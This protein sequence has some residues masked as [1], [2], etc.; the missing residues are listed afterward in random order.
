MPAVRR[1]RFATL[2]SV[3]AAGALVVSVAGCG[4]DDASHDSAKEHKPNAQPDGQH[5]DGTSGEGDSSDGKESPSLKLPSSVPT[6][7]EDLKDWDWDNWKHWA[8]QKVFKN[9]RLK[10]LWTPDRMK[11]AKPADVNVASAPS[12]DRPATDPKPA[13]VRAQKAD[14]PY[15][16]SDTAQVGKIFFDSP[17]GSMVC[18]GTVVQ[19]P[20]HPG[21]SN[22]V[23]TAGHC[24]HGGK[25]KGWYRNIEF[26][27]AYNDS[28]T[29][30]KGADPSD[31]RVAPFG[32]F[33]ASWAQTSSQWI[34]HGE[35]SGGHGSQYDFAVLRVTP[36]KGSHTSLQE[37][38]GGAMPLWF[39][40]PKR[41]SKVSAW[42]YPAAPPYNGQTMF[43]CSDRPSRL[44]INPKAPNLLR[45]GCTMTGGASGGGWFAKRP[46]GK[47]ALVSNTSIGPP[48]PQ[49]LAGPYLGN[50]AKAVFNAV[51]HGQH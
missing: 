35:A 15:S 25:G 39:N 3:L 10:D 20:A 19:D 28:G 1:S 45:I 31:R 9:P 41:L 46:D 4:T 12:A 18:S 5:S 11:K 16:K 47:T 36:P 32:E 44:S 22:L 43:H 38:V 21:K 40:A 8:K 50:T 48:L 2:G 7:V 29:A 23:W 13:P 33:W 34:R 6:S 26:V 27:P 17:K 37:A 30:W 24:V 49:W 14:P 42:G 51:S